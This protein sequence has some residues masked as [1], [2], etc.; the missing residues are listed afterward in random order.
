M[1]RPHTLAMCKRRAYAVNT[2][3]GSL[4]WKAELD[5][6][7]FAMIS[8]AP[9][10]YDGRLYVPV[11]SAEELGGINPKY[12]CCTFRGSV[13]ALDA[14][15]GNVIWKTYYDRDPRA[16]HLEPM[17]QGR[18]CWDLQAQPYGL[19]RPSTW[20]ARHSTS[21]LADNYSDPASSTSDAV[22]ALDLK[23]REDFCR[24]NN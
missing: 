7:P 12:P 8:G 16:G 15:T 2:A 10:L 14:K 20:I 18:K 21:V 17:R 23:E 6:H 5:Q 24:R 1:V 13:S 11:S 22:I 19:L 9:K 3:T 4:L